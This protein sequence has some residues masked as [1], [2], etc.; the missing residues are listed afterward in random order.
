MIVVT[1]HGRYVVYE[2]PELL[3]RFAEKNPEVD[4]QVI[5]RKNKDP[6][7]VGEYGKFL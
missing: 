3:K 5:E 1:S 2:Q 6:Q 4:V 7:L